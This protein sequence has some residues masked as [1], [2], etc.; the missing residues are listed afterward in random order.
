MS[1]RFSSQLSKIRAVIDQTRPRRAGLV[2]WKQGPMQLSSDYKQRQPVFANCPLPRG[3]GGAKRRVRA[4]RRNFSSSDPHPALRATFSP[5]E[6]DTLL[7]LGALSWTALVYDRPYFHSC[8]EKR[9]V[10]DRPYRKPS[11]LER[12]LLFHH[13]WT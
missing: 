8:T 6:K 3:E 11:I 13:A 2:G 1:A 12:F 4:A 5:R 9:A 10:I 7:T